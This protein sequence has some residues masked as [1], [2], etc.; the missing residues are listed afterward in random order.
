MDQLT[1]CIFN[2]FNMK[3]K[4]Y[5]DSLDSLHFFGGGVNF[6]NKSLKTKIWILICNVITT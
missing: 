5:I 4:L 1:L 2:N 3:N 6:Y